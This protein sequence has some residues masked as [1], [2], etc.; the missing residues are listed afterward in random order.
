[1]PCQVKPLATHYLYRSLYPV[2]S[3]VNVPKSSRERERDSSAQLVSGKL[4][5]PSNLNHTMCGVPRGRKLGGGV[6]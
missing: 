2:C 4:V 1:M 5:G 6:A 3:F